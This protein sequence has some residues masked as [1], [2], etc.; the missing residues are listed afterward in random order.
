MRKQHEYGDRSDGTYAFSFSVKDV[1]KETISRL[2]FEDSDMEA[3]PDTWLTQSG[4]L[5]KNI[6]RILSDLSDRIISIESTND[7]LYSLAFVVIDRRAAVAI[8]QRVESYV[9][10]MLSTLYIAPSE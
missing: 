9:L 10:S 6:R 1:S 7:P 3:T 8:Q 5:I 2:F 4:L